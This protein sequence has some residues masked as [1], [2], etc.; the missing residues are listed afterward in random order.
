MRRYPLHHGDA[1]RTDVQF[2]LQWDRRHRQ[3][4]PEVIVLHLES[5]PAEQ[6]ANWKGRTTRPFGPSDKSEDPNPKPSP[7]REKSEDPNSKS[8]TRSTAT[9]QRP[10]PPKAQRHGGHDHEHHHRP[11]HYC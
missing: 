8:E 2:A 1:A 5:E 4:L 11:H 7:V 9:A 3:L 10:D 6:G